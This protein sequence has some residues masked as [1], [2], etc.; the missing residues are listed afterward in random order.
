MSFEARF[1]L[2]HDNIYALTEITGLAKLHKA[3]YNIV[4]RIPALRSEAGRRKAIKYMG[5]NMKLDMNSAQDM[6]F[7]R[8]Y[9]AGTVYERGTTML[10]KQILKA[11]DVFVDAGACNGYYSLIASRSVGKGRVYAFEP[12]PRSYKRL[13]DNIALNGFE[14]ITPYNIAL[15]SKKGIARLNLSATNDGENSI[16]KAGSSHS[17]EVRMDRL[18]NIIKKADLIKIDVEG[19]ESD[20]ITGSEKLLG[21]KDVKIIAEYNHMAMYAAHKGY[22]R[23][24]K[25][26]QLRGFTVK[27]ILKDGT[28]S[29]PIHTHSQLQDLITNLYC[30]KQ[31]KKGA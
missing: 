16:V 11:G 26:V 23:V 27:E 9:R 17:I 5:F 20:V 8:H 15:G 7:Y 12:T 31:A 18:D 28:L 1:F 29:E 21:N 30:Y 13:A 10:I 4:H 14:N 6:D 2:H 24:I 19:L 25:L 3:A 22:D